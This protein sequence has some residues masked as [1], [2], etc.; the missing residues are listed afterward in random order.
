MTVC[1]VVLS[2]L[3]VSVVV[4]PHAGS[5]PCQSYSSVGQSATL[6]MW[7]SAVQVCLGLRRNTVFSVMRG[8]SSAG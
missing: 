8:I 6:I 2:L 5:Q 4:N 1:P 3:S 7:R